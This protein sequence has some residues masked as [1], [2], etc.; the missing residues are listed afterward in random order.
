MAWLGVFAFVRP[1]VGPV[2][3]V[4]EWLRLVIFTDREA[5]RR[6]GPRQVT[7]TTVL[8]YLGLGGESRGESRVNDPVVR[9]GFIQ[10]EYHRHK[11][12]DEDEFFYVVEGRLLID[13]EGRTGVESHSY[14]SSFHMTSWLEAPGRRRSCRSECVRETSRADSR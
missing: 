10:A 9:L 8:L 13:L 14:D 1:T 5:L 2:V 3:K 7:R 4:Q 11:H 6:A 12:D